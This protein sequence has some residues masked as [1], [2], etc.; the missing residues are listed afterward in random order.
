MPNP[1]CWSLTR[2]LEGKN[3]WP[4]ASV[5][6]KPPLS[7][8]AHG[9]PSKRGSRIRARQKSAPCS[10]SVPPSYPEAEFLL[11]EREDGSLAADSPRPTAVRRGSRPQEPCKPTM[12]HQLSEGVEIGVPLKSPCRAS[13]WV[14]PADPPDLRHV[15]KIPG[16]LPGL[17]SAI[18]I[19]KGVYKEPPAGAEGYVIMIL[20]ANKTSLLIHHSGR[21]TS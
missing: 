7:E 9:S 8:I 21:Q 19:S 3:T 12:P 11:V 10:A 1:S 16:Q 2:V 6:L 5:R 13:H 18:P 17:R 14:I 20:H 4:A 15:G